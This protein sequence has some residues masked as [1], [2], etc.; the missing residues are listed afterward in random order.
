MYLVIFHHWFIKTYKR[1][2]AACVLLSHLAPDWLTASLFIHFITTNSLTLFILPPE[3]IT[4][5]L[6]AWLSSAEANH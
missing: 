2:S 6:H 5:I 1:L 4:V 3:N